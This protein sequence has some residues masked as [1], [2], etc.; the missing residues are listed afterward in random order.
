MFSPDAYF[1]CETSCLHLHRSDD[2]ME[3]VRNSK[4]KSLPPSSH[5]LL[6][7]CSPPYSL[8]AIVSIG[9]CRW[10]RE[11][12]LI[13]YLTWEKGQQSNIPM[14]TDLP[15]TEGSSILQKEEVTYLSC[16]HCLFGLIPD[17][18]AE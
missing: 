13:R 4:Q 11:T 15:A 5:S 16:H 17:I 12:W 14:I 3:Q 1:S 6:L 18:N 10:Q 2:S 8:I 7:L 9:F